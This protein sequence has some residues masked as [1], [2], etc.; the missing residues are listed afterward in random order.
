M[1]PDEMPGLQIHLTAPSRMSRTR[2]RRG[3]WPRLAAAV[4]LAM[5]WMCAGHAAPAS[6]PAGAVCVT[7][8]EVRALS[9]GRFEIDSPAVRAVNRDGD[10]NYAALEF[11]YLGRSREASKLAS[12]VVKAQFGVKLQAEDGCNVLYIMW[13]V[14]GDGR[15]EV[16]SK[17]NPGRSTHAQCGVKGY[18][19]VEPKFSRPLPAL[20][21]GER[22]RIE[23]RVHKRMLEVRVDDK[24]VWRGDAGVRT[25]SLYGYPGL[26][27][28]NVHL[29]FKWLAE[30]DTEPPPPGRHKPKVA[31]H[32]VTP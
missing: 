6:V 16:S 1:T 31:C 29:K 23:A 15:L 9:D 5:G 20:S 10:D 30:Q 28:D 27:T 32:P 24:L 19:A 26:R 4:V 18:E 3:R 22:H 25:A 2:P 21:T 17:V 7:L 12:G 14:D 11:E 8:G 13:P